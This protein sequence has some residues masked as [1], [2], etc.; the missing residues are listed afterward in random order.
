MRVVV[1]NC[2]RGP[3]SRKLAYLDELNADVAIVPECPRPGFGNPALHAWCGAKETQGL[4]VFARSPYSLEPLS[5]VDGIPPYVMPVRVDG[6]R[7]FSL[8][9]V[10]TQKEAGY[11]RG[12]EQV[13]SGYADLF[14][15][16]PV[17][18][19]GDLNS[20]AIWN[21]KDRGYN[22]SDLVGELADLGLVSG[23][24]A[25]FGEEHGQESRP[26]HHWRRNP[27]APYHIDYCFVPSGWIEELEC[28]EVLDLPEGSRLSDH[29]P[30]V[31]QFG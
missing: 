23:Y 12:M 11:V 22:H 2:C 28:V 29:L 30:L 6:P 7:S 18:V 9:A 10:W 4:A 26:T 25:Y 27:E 5:A 17:V 15:G 31:V 16:G 19:A 13:L 3:L 14:S 8:L 24:H 21:R 1:W 20:N